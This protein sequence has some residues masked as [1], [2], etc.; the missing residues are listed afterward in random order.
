MQL[1]IQD[2]QKIIPHPFPFLLIDKVLECRPN[3]KLIALKNVS[4]NE[5]FF[6]GH[7]PKEKVMPGVLII[8]AIAQLVGVLLMQMAPA[9]NGA[10]LAL[11]TGVDKVRFRRRVVPGDQLR[12]EVRFLGRKQHFWKI[13]GVALVDGKVVCSAEM[14]CAQQAIV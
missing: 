14:M 12:L 4:I 13:A 6:V 2:I 10:K 9:G 3:E 8:E 11:L 1:N 5:P 7:F